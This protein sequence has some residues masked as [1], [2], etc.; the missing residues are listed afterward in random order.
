MTIELDFG[1][2]ELALVF[3]QAKAVFFEPLKNTTEVLAWPFPN[4]MMSSEMFLHPGRPVRISL[5]AS[6]K[7]S[8]A[9]LIPNGSPTCV[10]KVV[11]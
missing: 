2:G 4:T 10:L 8:D 1:L 6:W 7:I 3:V 9:A 11:T 5:I